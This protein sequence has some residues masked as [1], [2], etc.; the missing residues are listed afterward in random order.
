MHA[1]RHFEFGHP[2]NGVA[3][4]R[5]PNVCVCVRSTGPLRMHACMILSHGNDAHVS[6]RMN[7]PR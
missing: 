7:A 5:R 6:T 1:Q 3:S 2:L 4:L